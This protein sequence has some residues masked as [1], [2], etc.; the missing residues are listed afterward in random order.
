MNEI[1]EDA[2]YNSYERYFYM[3]HHY[4]EGLIDCLSQ[5]LGDIIQDEDSEF[6]LRTSLGRILSMLSI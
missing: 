4:K 5:I 6:L 1:L 2:G 3:Q